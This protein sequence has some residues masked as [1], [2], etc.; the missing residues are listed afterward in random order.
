MLLFLSGAITTGYVLVGLFFLRFWQRT[1]DVLFA[2]FAVAF[3]LLA[4]NQAFIS[5]SGIAREHESWVYLLRAAAFIL[6]I[7]GITTKNIPTRRR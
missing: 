2:T 4:A 5:T 1:R 6:I 3:W 7:V